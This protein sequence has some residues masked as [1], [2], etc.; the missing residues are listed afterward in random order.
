MNRQRIANGIAGLTIAL[1]FAVLWVIAYE[2]VCGFRWRAAEGGTKWALI[3]RQ[4]HFRD[5]SSLTPEFFWLGPD[6]CYQRLMYP[7][8]RAEALARGGVA[9]GV[10]VALAGLLA[11]GY[12][13]TRPVK[14]KGDARWGDIADAA[15]GALTVKRGILFGKLNGIWLRSDAPAHILVVGPS[16]SGKGTSFLLPNGYDHIGS[17]VW[18]DIKRENY[19]LLARYLRDRGSK[20]FIFNPG[21]TH[22]HRYNPLDFIRGGPHMPTDCGTAASFIIPERA[23][24][25]WSGAGRML[26]ATLIGYV[27]SSPNCRG[28]RHLRSVA[29]MTVTGKD[30]SAVL[31]SLVASEGAMLPNWICDGFNQYVALEPEIRNSAVFNI[32]MA[33]NPWNNHLISAV[34]ETSDF[35]IRRLREERAAIFVVCGIAELVQFRPII[36][37]LFQQIHDLMMM[38]RPKAKDRYEVLLA[39]D[40]FRHLGPMPQLLSMLTNSAGYNFRM[41]IVIQSISMLDELYGKPVRQTKLAG[42]QVKLFIKIDDLDTAIYVSEMLG[43]RTI[44]VETPG[45]RVGTGLFASKSTQTHYEAQPLMSAPDLRLL[46]FGKSILFVSGARPFLIEK[47]QHYRDQPFK[48]FLERYGDMKASPP[49]LGEWKDGDI[50]PLLQGRERRNE[51][52]KTV[53]EDS[54][55]I[56]EATVSSP[57]PANRGTLDVATTLRPREAATTNKSLAPIVGGAPASKPSAPRRRQLSPAPAVNGV[58]R[59]YPTSVVVEAA[60]SECDLAFRELV[61]PLAEATGLA[62]LTDTLTG[63]NAAFG[64]ASNDGGSFDS[65]L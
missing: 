8:M 45:Q 59:D 49:M 39:L 57:A 63:L 35:D 62:R 53:E 17:S 36:R 58:V 44:K 25:T 27:M 29:R 41:A 28:Q 47:V 34:T 4:L 14:H 23:D 43:D 31:R 30:I 33:M 24:D 38:E 64:Q 40:E 55:L 65:S 42:S 19:D 26:L 16:R 18:W 20:V 32:N 3:Q 50:G 10:L 21:A 2:I 48:G 56:D 6:H 22:S 52:P 9:A 37:I 13:A 11:V 60:H 7:P 5:W 51:P 61:G 46:S 54:E 1:L 12:F 15:K